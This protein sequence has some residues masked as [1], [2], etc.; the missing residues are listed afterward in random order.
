MNFSN[1]AWDAVYVYF[2]SFMR[3]SWM[4]GDN[5]AICLL[6]RMGMSGLWSVSIL[7][8]G[9]L[10]RY[11]FICLQPHMTASISISIGYHFFSA[12]VKY[13]E[14]HVMGYQFSPC[15][16]YRMTAIPFNL[17]PSTLIFVG[18]LTSYSLKFS[19][20]IMTCFTL[21]KAWVWF[22]VHSHSFL[23]DIRLHNGAEALAKLMLNMAIWLAIPMKRRSCLMFCG[24]GNFIARNA[25]FLDSNRRIL[26]SSI[27]FPRNSISYVQICISLGLS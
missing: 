6:L 27:L 10:W 5:S 25:S 16:W 24:C 8:L 12:G 3:I 21:L 18:R 23:V 19:G 1:R 15:C 17:L 22:S 26:P 14:P 20:D 13:L 7:K 4:R 9:R 11:M 2:N